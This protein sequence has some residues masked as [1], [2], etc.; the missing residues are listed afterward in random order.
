M[1]HVA[2]LGD[3]HIPG[4]ARDL[5]PSCWRAIEAADTVVHT[6]DVV[7]PALLERI[8]LVRPVHAV[9]GNNDTELHDLPEVLELTIAGVRVGVV[10]DTGATRGRRAR[11]RRRFPAARVVLFGHSHV[12]LLED[13]GD[14]MLLNPGSPTDRRRMPSF[15]MARLDLTDGHVHAEIL[16]L[17]LERAGGPAPRRTPSEATASGY[18]ALVAQEHSFDVVSDFERQEL[19]NAVDQ[20]R[21]EIANRYDFKNVT[22]ELELEKEQLVI[23]TA[24]QMQ[25]RAITDVLQS[26]LHKRGLDLRILDPQKPEDAARGNVRQV[27]K[28][29]RGIDDDLSRTLQKRIRTDHPKVQVRIQGDQLR[30]SAKDKDALQ[31]V[32]ASLR[33]DSTI[34]VP[35]QFTN[36]R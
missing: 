20:T 23:L 31:A 29:R 4:R 12:P 26:K 6:G 2:V 25:L 19:V 9:R 11:L 5:P 3:T 18:S 34:A 8:G 1:T 15:T 16:D 30:V 35:L 13:D 24:G 36:Y 14:L 10:H 33:D 17:G 7:A 22:A 28:L 27:V 21:R 32:I